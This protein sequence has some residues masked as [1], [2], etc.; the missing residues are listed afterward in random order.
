MTHPLPDRAR[1]RLLK[2]ASLAAAALP[3]LA[4]AATAPQDAGMRSGAGAPPAPARG[5]NSAGPDLDDP[6]TH[7]RTYVRMR[8]ATDGRLV[9]DVTQGF[10]YAL[11]P[12]GRPRLLLQSRGVQLARYRE[13]ADGAWVCRSSYF[14]SFADAA[15]GALLGHWDNPFTAQRDVVPPTLYGPMDY[16]LTASRTLVN[17]SPAQRAAALAER[18]VRRWTRI[19][20]LVTI[21]DELGPTDDLARPPDLDVISLGARVAD[22]AD[23]SLAS[24]PSQMAFG[25]VE[26][27]RDWMR[28]GERPG[29]LLWHLQGTKVDGLDAVPSDLLRAAETRRPGFVAQASG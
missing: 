26:P 9:V 25:A 14:G 24:V 18:A 16:V 28:M 10:V 4:W 22:L 15:S 6:G 3:P 2:S 29:M 1:R 21:V 8:G 12:S 19:G 23:D 11:R 5:G 17:P 7:L 27:W 20:D 13:D